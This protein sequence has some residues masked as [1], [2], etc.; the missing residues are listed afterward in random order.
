M[1]DLRERVLD[2]PES[3]GRL[4]RRHLFGLD[5]VDATSLDPVIDELMS[6]GTRST[7]G[8]RAPVVV[9]P[10]VD[11][12]VHLDRKTDHVSSELTHSA[13]MV[14]PDGQ[15]VVW[16]SRWLGRPLRARLTGSTLIHEMWPRIVAEGAR[17]VVI[18]SSEDIAALVE[19]DGA[20]CHAIVAPVIRLDDHAGLDAFVDT[21][22]ALIADADAEFV[23]VTLGYPKQCHIIA[24]L[25]ERLPASPATFL[26]IGASFDM[27]YGFVR[28]APHWVQR[29]GMEWAFRLMQE[30]RRLF[31]RYLIDDPSFVRIVNQEHRRLR[32]LRR[33]H[34]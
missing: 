21:C 9:T 14:L 22:A 11:Q 24:G 20:H 27:H 33:A 29:I 17:S 6:G 25:L 32:S 3:A 12:L 8:D 2:L 18:A 28:R 7:G 15:P 5:F 4:R 30:P 26:A 19:A 16:A 13:F 10:N 34:A 31:R 1:V 23:F